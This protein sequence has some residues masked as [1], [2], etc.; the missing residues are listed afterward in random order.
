MSD[1]SPAQKIDTLLGFA[2]RAGRLVTGATAVEVSLRRN[3]TRL[4]LL[5]SDAS[6]WTLRSLAA[7]AFRN[8]VRVFVYST[9]EDLGRLLGKGMVAAIGVED[10]QFARSLT[11]N[12]AVAPEARELTEREMFPRRRRG[13][14]DARRKRAR[15]S[16]GAER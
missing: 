5:A 10:S 2:R 1:S 9:K 12:L 8:G 7:K 16:G 11:V 6:K 3:R 13:G 4:L 15:R 14:A